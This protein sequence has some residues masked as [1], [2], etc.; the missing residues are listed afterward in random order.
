[1]MRGKPVFS[2]WKKKGSEPP[3]LGQELA[4]QHCP[5]LLCSAAP[6]DSTIPNDMFSTLALAAALLSSDTDT[7]LELDDLQVTAG[8]YAQTTFEAGSAITVINPD[9]PGQE[10]PSVIT[11]MLRYQ[12]GVYVQQ[13]TPGQGIP[14]VRG[15][16]GSEVL[17]LVDGMR[18][19]NAFFRNAPNQYLA[20]VDALNVDHIEVVRGPSS[21]LYGG[22]AMGGVVQILTPEPRFE[23]TQFNARVIADSA[24]D[25]L[26]GRASFSGGNEKAAIRVGASYSD[27]GDRRIGGGTTLAPSGYRAE[28]YDL[29]GLFQL[30]NEIELMA[31]VQ[32]LEQPSTPRVD[33]LIAGFGQT[34]PDSEE[35]FFEP[36]KRDF[37]HTRLFW[38]AQFSWVDQMEFHL[39]RQTIDDNRRS[40]NTGSTSRRLEQNSSTLDGATAQFSKLAKSGM[41]WTY[42]LEYY[43]DSVDS[44]RQQL[45]LNSGELSNVNAR[46]ADGS[47]MDSFAIYAQMEH[48]LSDR[49]RASAGARYS[50]YDIDIPAGDRGVGAKLSPDDITGNLSALY[51]LN[52]NLNLIANLGRG[53]RPPNIF[54][55]S[56]LGERPG[57][58]FNIPNPNLAP[59]TVL[60][61]D[62][63]LRHSGNGWRAEAFAYVSDYTDQIVSV[64]TGDMT[65]DGRS[66][67]RSENAGEVRLHGFEIGFNGD[68]TDDLGVFGTLN[69]TYGKETTGGVSQAADRIPPLNGR[70]GL[71]YFWLRGSRWQVFSQFADDQDRLSDRDISDPRINPE[72]T[73]GWGTI[74]FGV[75]FPVGQSFEVS[76]QAKNITDKR[77]REHASG[78]DA[79]GRNFIATLDYTW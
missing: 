17:H 8:R 11:D 35:F 44:R 15:L 16:K 65:P 60:T 20:L 29:K 32:N 69:Y 72:G 14:I 63:G 53:F 62:I 39:A 38:D 34:E 5:N 18:L 77:Y 41:L 24:H 55:L 2:L 56:T 40:R 27:I 7:P 36:N 75:D 74:N 73:P 52:T 79:P 48:W 51:Q 68:L 21:T 64:A 1:M 4:A 54:D 33:E 66:I 23:E 26:Q 31:A 37:Y 59:E 57:N 12:P 49:F 45:D 70:L 3:Y 10:P 50:A 28:A 25:R 42:G 46:F 47:S 76:L 6:R 58:R 67:V 30:S 22:D 78:I 9:G 19:N 13:T 43:A 71:E 61:F